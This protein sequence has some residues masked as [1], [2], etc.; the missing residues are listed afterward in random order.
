M[1]KTVRQAYVD[2][3]T[4]LVKEESPTLYLEDFLYYYNKAINEY[5][6]LRYELFEMT[7]QLT[8]DLRFWK[9]KY[10]TASLVIPID[11]IGAQTGF[12]YRHLLNCIIT[13]KLK[14]PVRGCTTD[15]NGMVVKRAQ[16]LS[17]NIKAGIVDNVYLEPS[18]RRPY[19][20]IINNTI[21]IY[22]GNINTNSI[23]ISNIQIEYLTNPKEVNLTEEEVESE[24]DTSE[25]LEFTN[26]VGDEINKIALKLILERG[27]NPR[28]QSNVAVNQSVNDISVKGGGK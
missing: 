3:L 5:L 8:D 19:F 22:I 4:E 2:I 7:Q 18:I 9:K 14:R 25:V 21:E 12:D 27:S 1:Y 23:E 15:S 17:S 16:R 13:F 26:D 11:E 28:L 10:E 24:I 6:K 20:D